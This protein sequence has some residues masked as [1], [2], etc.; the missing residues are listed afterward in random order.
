MNGNQG[1]RFGA[2]TPTSASSSFSRRKELCFRRSLG[3][4]N[5]SAHARMDFY[6]GTIIV[7]VRSGV[8]ASLQLAPIFDSAPN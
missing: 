4:H 3:M 6:G 5:A 7:C 8:V 2:M 1:C